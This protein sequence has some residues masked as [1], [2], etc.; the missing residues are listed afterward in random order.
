MDFIKPIVDAFQAMGA[1][2][3]N[4]F[5]S[6][7]CNLTQVLKTFYWFQGWPVFATKYVIDMLEIVN[8]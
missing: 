3:K 5:H 1:E 7:F 4:M 8:F 2:R 6:R